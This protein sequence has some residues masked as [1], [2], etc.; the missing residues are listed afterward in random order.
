MTQ[1]QRG[2]DL[3]SSTSNRGSTVAEPGR[4]TRI[5]KRGLAVALLA[6]ALV[7]LACATT[8]T[9]QLDAFKAL[10][11]IRTS[12]VAAVGVFNQGYQSGQFTEVQRTQLGVL[13]NKYVAADAVAATALQ[14]TTTTDPTTIV[15][16]VTALAGDVLN[17]VSLL[18]NQPTPIPAVPATHP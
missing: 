16:T 10:Q 8:T 14:A 2:V 1:R 12:V 18:K 9:A 5:G 15:Q 4:H 3:F 13:Y 6:A 7:S 11:T 17:F